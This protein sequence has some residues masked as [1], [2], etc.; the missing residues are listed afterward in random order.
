MGGNVSILK[1]WAVLCFLLISG[2]L[3][4]AE[5]PPVN[6]G[7][8]GLVHGHVYGFIR[9]LQARPDV[10]LVGIAE[11]DLA[12]AKRYAESFN[13]PTQLFYT[14]LDEMLARTNV[15]AAAL[16]TTTYD[17][18]IAVETCAMA[19]VH[20]VMME[21]PLAVD[22]AGA[23]RILRAHEK[24]DTQII[25]NYETTW[26][27][28]TTALWRLVKVRGAIGAI[29]KMA[30]QDGHN[31]PE[32]YV[33]PEFYNWLFNPV[34]NGAGAL[35]DFGC[36]GANLMTWLMDD[37]RPLTV[38][39]QTGTFRP[40]I[41]P[42]VDDD[43]TIIVEYPQATG[44]IEASWN[45][46]FNVKDFQVFG[47]KG[48]LTAAAYDKNPKAGETLKAYLPGMVQAEPQAVGEPSAM[49]RDPISYLV[50]VARGKLKPAGLSSLQNNLI[51][52]EI[53]VAARESARTGKRIVLPQHPPW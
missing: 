22:M 41:N 20:A 16:F 39:A 52:T 1:R 11:A 10:R 21:K 44:V 19:G 27:P 7:I 46:P 38:T 24:Y 15:E 9:Q 18:T 43:A 53:L 14:N 42:K 32:H 23:R 37:Q 8:V 30:S 26:Y 31:G 25:V 2:N 48:Y 3:L 28:N 40:Q 5:E 34:K 6:I 13:L 33:G 35:F 45:W 17:H 50:A 4:Q 49:E 36:Y 47:E 51:V 29:R 12:L